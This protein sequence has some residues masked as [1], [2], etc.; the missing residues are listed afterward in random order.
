MEIDFVTYSFFTLF[1]IVF[2][3]AAIKIL[4]EYERGVVFTLGRFTSVRGPGLI[5]LIPFVQQ[6]VRVDLR[7]IVLD[8]PTQDVISRDNV[9][10]QVNAVIYF[11]VVDPERAIIQVEEFLEATS[12]LAQTTLRS[13]LGKHE[14]DEM[15]TERDKL[16]QD[17][18]D[19]IDTQTDAWGIKVANVEIK[20]VDL[21]ETMIRAIAKQ[22]EAE[23]IRRAKIINAEGEQQAAKKLTD[24]ARILATED[25]AMQLRY[26]GAL[27][28]F[29]GEK[30]STVVL[31]LPFDIMRMFE[32]SKPA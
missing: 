14:L 7:T 23:R 29:S 28:E 1:A 16:N 19:I 6:M 10:V 25:G 15:L 20:H 17:I 11:R 21:N 8:V 27:Q 4:R 13:V 31:P 26:L 24:A 30:A 18:Q 2:L 9:S 5:I 22:A 32:K 3:A 12:Q